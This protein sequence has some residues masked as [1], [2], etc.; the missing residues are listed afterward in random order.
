MHSDTSPDEESST[1]IDIQSATTLLIGQREKGTNMSTRKRLMVFG[2]VVAIASGM[3]LGIAS[4]NVSANEP[5]LSPV[6]P[7]HCEGEWS[8]ER[9][10]VAPEVAAR[11]LDGGS[12]TIDLMDERGRS[13]ASFDLPLKRSLVSGPC[14]GDVEIVEVIETPEIRSYIENNRPRK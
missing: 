12:V 6:N 13:Q 11:A 10:P 1:Q 9:R 14:G 7:P 4:A 2:G 8:T 5:S 3:G